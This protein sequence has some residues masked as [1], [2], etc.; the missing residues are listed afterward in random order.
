[1][2]KENGLFFSLRIIK[3]LL[4]FTG[5]FNELLMNSK[6]LKTALFLLLLPLTYNAKCQIDRPLLME[7]YAKTF[8]EGEFILGYMESNFTFYILTQTAYYELHLIGSSMDDTR[9]WEMNYYQP[10]G[11]LLD[12]VEIKDLTWVSNDSSAFLVSEGSG[13]IYQFTGNGI[14]RLLNSYDQRSNDASAYFIYNKCIYNFSGYGYWQ[15]PSFI[16]KYDLKTNKLSAFLPNDGILVPPSSIRPLHFFNEDDKT[17][18][19]WGG[20]KV[21]YSNAVSSFIDNTN[22]LWSLNLETKLWNKIA[23][24]NMPPAFS[25]NMN[26]DTFINFK[27]DK[28]LFCILGTRLYVFNIFNNVISTY[29]IS[30]DFDLVVDANIQ[31]AYSRSSKFLLLSTLPY[32]NQNVRRVE[33]VTL[34]N[35]K[36]ELLSE[37][38][39][40]KTHL[41][42]YFNIGLLIVFILGLA[43][44]LYYF[45]KNYFVFRNKLIIIQ[46][47][48][49]IK[50]N[51]KL[52]KVLDTEESELVFWIAQSEGFVSTNYIMD[53]PSDGSQSYESLKKRKLNTMKSIEVKLGSYSQVKKSVFIERKSSED[54]RLKEYKL[55]ND[56]IIIKD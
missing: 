54:L 39:L 34:S 27:S 56:W 41:K 1:M 11:L 24:V 30:E 19:V 33:F 7:K 37:T 13:L 25:D 22:D 2:N 3:L 6:L 4:R 21:A 31:P 12:N 49:N 52:I 47:I 40:Q 45:Y 26:T 9:E 16:S 32:P 50:F 35:Y 8:I 36:S 29:K 42:T 23:K 46:S 55:N 51:T 28:E 53:R 5:A 20:E 38:K 18:Y 14:V 17:L 15:Y 44:L 43:Y 48:K 10:N